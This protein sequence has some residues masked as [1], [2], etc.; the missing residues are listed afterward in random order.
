MHEGVNMTEQDVIEKGI[1]HGDVFECPTCGAIGRIDINTPIGGKV[2]FDLSV[3]YN[4]TMDKWEC[5]DCWLK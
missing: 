2:E 3:W 5:S 1:K 4:K